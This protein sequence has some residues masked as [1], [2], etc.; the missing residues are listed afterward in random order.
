MAKRILQD[1]TVVNIITSTLTNTEDDYRLGNTEW[2]DGT[3]SDVVLEA[4]APSLP[5]PPIIV[6]IQHTVNHLFMKRAVNY[7]LQAYKRYKMDPVLLV[8]CVDTLHNDVSQRVAASRFPDCDSFPCYPWAQNCI[9]HL[10]RR[11]VLLATLL[12]YTFTFSCGAWPL[13]FE[14]FSFNGF[15]IRR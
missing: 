6:E 3:R 10:F 13:F 5:L 2:A 12:R 15:S 8:I 14:P 1:P 9:I 11:K 4:K 7:C